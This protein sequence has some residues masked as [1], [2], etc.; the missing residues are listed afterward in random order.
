M[1]FACAI[2]TVLWDIK[3]KVHDIALEAAATSIIAA[4]IMRGD[5]SLISAEEIEAEQRRT[6]KL[7]KDYK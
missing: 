1:I 2:L 3:E 5:Q 6:E 4:H 7:K